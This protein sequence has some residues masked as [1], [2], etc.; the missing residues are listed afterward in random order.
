VTSD[1][2][3][4]AEKYRH[5]LQAAL[6]AKTGFLPKTLRE[7]LQWI[8]DNAT[9]MHAA[10]KASGASLGQEADTIEEYKK[11]L[12]NT[13]PG[14]AFD[15]VN[16]RQIIERVIKEIEEACRILE[17][18]TRAGVVYGVAPENGLRAS[19][20]SV[21]QTE[22]SII[23]VT[24][25]F[26]SFC[27]LITKTL[28]RSLPQQLLGQQ[29]SISHDP[30][31]VRLKLQNNPELI[32]EWTRIL[33]S[34]AEFGLPPPRVQI[35]LDEATQALRIMLLKAVELFAIAHEYGH[36]VLMHGISDTSEPATDPILDEHQADFF[37]SN[38][39]LV[40]GSHDE[41]P[42]LY[43]MSGTGGLIILGMLDLVRR[44]VAVLE[45]GHDKPAPLKTHPPLK[46]R[47]RVIGLLDRTMA[48]SEAKIAS[49]MR[50]YFAEIIEVIWDA[51]LPPILK[52]HK[53]GRR[54]LDG[55]PDTGGWLPIY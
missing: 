30:S 10:A 6:A 12:L 46:E 13:S 37:A 27:N 41:P 17:I 24:V 53:E 39:S 1:D 33:A 18:P 26:L 4:T 34:Y 15:D 48:Q 50:A 35:V 22:A 45:S 36:H 51:A 43:A 3:D 2:K 29:I 40:V 8:D 49:E 14:S 21:L 31:A 23:D 16:A 44:A 52:L 19:L 55:A 38:I 20:L 7:Q 25:P 54:P 5:Q 11:A 42:N 28:A 47:I 32:D 9:L